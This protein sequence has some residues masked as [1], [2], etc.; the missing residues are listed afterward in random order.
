MCRRSALGFADRAFQRV[1]DREARRRA[2]RRERGTQDSSRIHDT[3]ATRSSPSV[4]FA[5]SANATTT[6]RPRARAPRTHA[7]TYTALFACRRTRTRY[8]RSSTRLCPRERPC[9]PTIHPR[10]RTA[11]AAAVGASQRRTRDNARTCDTRERARAGSTPRRASRRGRAR[12]R[13]P[14]AARRTTSRAT[15]RPRT[16]LARSSRRLGL[17]VRGT[18]RSGSPQI[19][20]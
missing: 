5:A 18:G 12:S 17:G 3:K 14:R 4:A 9:G 2:G 19:N 10:P 1:V 20:V 13:A 11:N 7:K 8:V 6:T 16:P 15:R